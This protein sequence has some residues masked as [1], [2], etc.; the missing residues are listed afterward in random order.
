LCVNGFVFLE[1]YL[2]N[3]VRKSKVKRF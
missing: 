1:Q 2:I 3:P